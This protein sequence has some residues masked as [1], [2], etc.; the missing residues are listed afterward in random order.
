MNK[1]KNKKTLFI[2]VATLALIAVGGTF[3]YYAD[4]MIFANG[5][6]TGSF[7]MDYVETFDSPD[8]WSPCAETAKTIVATNRSTMPV[9]VRVK[10][11][12]SWKAQNNDNLPLTMNIDGKNEK[13]AI[14][15]FDN[16]DKW[17]YDGEYYN[18]YR[19]L[20]PGETTESLIKSVTFNC[21]VNF[22]KEDITYV[23]TETGTIGTSSENEYLKS[24]YHLNINI[25][26]T[27]AE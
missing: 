25:Q 27:Q 10:L 19:N 12:E 18:Y 7:V 24:K 8:N 9:S 21:D 26:A 22:V 15:N 20:K 13:I 4:R 1:I 16:T 3:A 23:E 2:M 6:T 17:T 5:F 14:I 11:D